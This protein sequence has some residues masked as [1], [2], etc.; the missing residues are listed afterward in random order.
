MLL[1]LLLL[2]FLIFCRPNSWK[3]IN[4]AKRWQKKIITW[5]CEFQQEIVVKLEGELPIFHV[6]SVI[7]D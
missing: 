3:L 4:W 2:L 1:L 7:L 6:K 5:P